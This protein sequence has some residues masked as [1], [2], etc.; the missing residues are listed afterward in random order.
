M[1]L[2]IGEIVLD[3]IKT[4][5]KVTRYVG[6]APL[7]VA[8]NCVLAGHNAGFGWCCGDDEAG[9]YLRRRTTRMG[10]SYLYLGLTKNPT[11]KSIVTLSNGERDFTFNTNK[12]YPKE[13]ENLLL[14][15]LPNV[16]LLHLGSLYLG[17]E[18]GYKFGLNL[19]KRMH[20]KGLKVSFDVNYRRHIF[21]SDEEAKTRLTTYV[22][23]VDII[24]MSVDE[25]ILLYGTHYLAPLL[26]LSK[27]K[28]IF[29]TKG[30]E[31]SI[32]IDNGLVTECHDNV[33]NPVDTTGAGDAFFAQA[34]CYLVEHHF[35]IN[36]P[37]ELL[38]L[39]NKAGA[40]ATQHKGALPK[41]KI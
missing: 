19:I 16:E 8:V 10:L 38:T 5:N 6:G 4:D 11:L 21:K 36:N 3:E 17:E 9:S 34:L 23:N 7:N 27:E 33:L 28:T 15:H 26:S 40:K 13:I 18:A 37:L 25:A 35:N 31:G 22:N 30:K 32:L 41:L 39:A 24:K 29:V 20:D 2:C 14:D 12:V 1:I